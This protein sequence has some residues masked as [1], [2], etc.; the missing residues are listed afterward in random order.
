MKKSE[1]VIIIVAVVA[2]IAIIL[3]LR[4]INVDDKYNWAESYR[5]RL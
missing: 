3:L 1:I 2:F 4:L 5:S